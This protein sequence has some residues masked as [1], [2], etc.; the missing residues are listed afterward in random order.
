M[1]LFTVVP[2]G[3]L[4][5]E[6]A[7]L[8]ADLLDC[9]LLL[10]AIFAVLRFQLTRQ[11]MLL[12]LA[13]LAL[14]AASL[15]LSFQTS[16]LCGV[17]VLP[18]SEGSQMIRLC[19]TYFGDLLGVEDS[20]HYS[21]LL[22]PLSIVGTLGLSRYFSKTLPFRIMLAGIV[23]L[24]SMGLGLIFASGAF[25]SISLTLEAEPLSFFGRAALCAFMPVVSL[26]ASGRAPRKKAVGCN[27]IALASLTW[28]FCGWLSQALLPAKSF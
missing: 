11:K 22:L 21:L 6:N 15:E 28:I 18:N 27:L 5:L 1:F 8:R 26:Q 9:L 3:V 13:A 25:N 2:N 10:V 17:G 16:Y 4:F 12:A 24:V 7:P 14:L 19:S 20:R 23:C